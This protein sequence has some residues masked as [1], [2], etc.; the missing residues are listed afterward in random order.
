MRWYRDFIVN[1]PEDLN[2]F[3]AFLTVPPARLSPRSCTTGRCARGLV[4]HRTGGEGRGGLRPRPEVGTPELHGV[5]A[6]PFPLCKA[7]RRA[8]PDG[9]VVL[10]G[11]LHRRALRRGH[12]AAHEVRGGSHAAVHH[13]PLPDKRRG[14]PGRKERHA[15]SYR[16]ANWGMV[17]VGV[18]PDPA[19]KEILVDWT[20]TT[21]KRYTRTRP[22][23]HT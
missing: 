3:F 15:W 4:L 7:P 21:G 19:N 18:D 17:I 23:E 6:M 22:V 16:E 13:A 9:P 20:R 8:L 10:E 1:A 2:G 12:R 14:A 11:G 5:G